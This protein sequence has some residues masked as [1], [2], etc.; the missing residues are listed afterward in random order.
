MNLI[1]QAHAQIKLAAENLE[2]IRE[3]SLKTECDNHQAMLCGT[4]EALLTA[5]N[6]LTAAIEAK[7]LRYVRRAFF[8]L[9]I[10]NTA[11]SLMINTE[12]VSICA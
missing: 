9:T 10:Q 4:A 2:A 3:R 11:I 7:N 12:G 1:E 5:S 8:R 6:N